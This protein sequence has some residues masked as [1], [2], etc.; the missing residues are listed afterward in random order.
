MTTRNSPASA[1]ARENGSL[2]LERGGEQ[3]GGWSD[4]CLCERDDVGGGGGG[5][6]DD[7]AG[8]HNFNNGSLTS[9]R[10]LEDTPLP[11]LNPRNMLRR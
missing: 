11:Q 10:F 1:P 3:A 2:V 8:E 4:D 7:V 5:D 9:P 6:E